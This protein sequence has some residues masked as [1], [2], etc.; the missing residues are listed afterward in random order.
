[1]KTKLIAPIV[2]AA[3]LAAASIAQAAPVTV[4]LYSFQSAG[5]AAA[6]FKVR[7]AKCKK[8]TNSGQMAIS[9]G[10]GTNSCAY[11]T[12]VVADSSDKLA[13]QE[14]SAVTVL[15]KRIPRKL[16]KK[17]YTAVSVR[18]SENAGYELRVRP[19]ARSWQVFR[20]PKGGAP[21]VLMAGGKGK[22]IRPKLGKV[23]QL[24]LRAFDYGSG[25]TRLLALVNGKRAFATTDAAGNQPDGRR[26]VV[27]TGTK[28][29][30]AGGGIVGFFDNV[31]VRVP[32]PF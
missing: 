4:A 17:A 11:R 14:A 12:S 28:G 29:T 20:D 16:Q 22:F 15:A 1:M 2:L 30:G 3:A 5:D 21:A 8:D 23:N 18:S 31:A 9:V 32:N 19:V 10:R 24:V 13:D 6:F 25:S 7:G 26:T 27:A